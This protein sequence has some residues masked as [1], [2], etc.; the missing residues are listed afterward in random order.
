MYVND[1]YSYHMNKV[2][3]ERVRENRCLF[4]ALSSISDKNLIYIDYRGKRK[5]PVLGTVEF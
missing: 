4:R 5:C 3:G 1:I 2:I